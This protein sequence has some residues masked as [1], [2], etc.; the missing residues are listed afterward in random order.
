MTKETIADW[1]E[2]ISQQLRNGCYM[3]GCII[4]PPKGM[5]AN[6]GCTCSPYS[7]SREL[8]RIARECEGRSSW[9]EDKK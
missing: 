4:N 1:L 6:G 3:H 9:K 7:I 2:R 5:A 8:H